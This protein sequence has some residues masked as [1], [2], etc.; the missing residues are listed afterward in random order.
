MTYVG[1]DCQINKDLRLRVYQAE[2]AGLYLRDTLA[3]FAQPALGD[4]VLTTY[5]RSFFSDED[6][7]AKAE[8]VDNTQFLGADRLSPGRASRDAWATCTPV[9]IRPRLMC[10]APS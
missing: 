10:P 4:G 6:G 1:C 8:E 5:L 9:A 2:V 7:V 3:F